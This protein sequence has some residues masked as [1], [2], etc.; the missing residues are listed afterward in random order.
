MKAG[1]ILW[2][3]VAIAAPSAARANELNGVWLRDDGKVRVNIAAC[4]DRTCATN[5]WVRDPAG[6]EAVGD[7]LVM[8][9]AKQPDGSL[10]GTAQDPKRGLNM[11]I[12]LRVASNRFTSRGCLLGRVV[13][14]E[15]SWTAAR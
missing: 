1:R 15:V 11:S 5:V 12:T 10:A 2:L 14:R 3:A 8:Q 7:R 6:G 9:L 4:G 13:C